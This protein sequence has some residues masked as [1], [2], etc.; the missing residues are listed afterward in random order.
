[1][2]GVVEE[3][4]RE[5][6]E[7]SRK[8]SGG[9]NREAARRCLVYPLERQQRT[10]RRLVLILYRSTQSTSCNMPH[11]HPFIQALL[12]YTEVHCL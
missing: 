6:R 1:M 7:E 3:C 8:A 9:K 5:Y 10:N 2:L 11:S 4:L 12:F